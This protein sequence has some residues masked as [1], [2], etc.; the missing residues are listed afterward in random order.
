MPTL[1]QVSARR[2]L[3][4]IVLAAAAASAVAAPATA[5]QFDPRTD[6]AMRAGR[7]YLTPTVAVRE[8]GVD[9]NVFNDSEQKSDFTVTLAPDVTIWA[10]L[11]N[12]A[13]LR[14]SLGTDLVYYQT[15]AS[16]RSIDP[17]MQ[18]RAEVSLN[19][20][21]LFV[22]PSYLSTRQRLNYEVD[23]RA[24]R[25]ERT[26]E[27]GGQFRVSRTL[28][29]EVAGR[30]RRVRFD[31]DQVFRGT[32]LDDSL[33]RE[34][35][36]VSAALTYELT[37]LTAVVL[38][39][40][41]GADRFALSPSRDATSLRV[42]PGVEFKPHALVTGTAHVGVRRFTPANP[43]LDPFKGVV[44]AVALETTVGDSMR[45]S[46]VANRDVEYSYEA[47][48]QYF[49]IRGY[50]AT[51]T[52]QLVGRTDVSLGALRQAHSYR[53][54]HQ[55]G[56][57]RPEPRRIDHVRTVNASVGYRFVPASRVG[58]GFE[59]LSRGSNSASHGRAYHGTRLVTTASYGF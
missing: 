35:R 24:R 29:L 14:T 33:N 47:T 12:R 10:P 23:A 4:R 46:V 50:G 40:E 43:L 38:R 45:V 8:F 3:A 11:S 37:P 26:L 54:L 19:R 27:A 22:Q 49:V 31:G 58:V 25:R 53:G 1:P 21:T 2:T 17:E 52:R 41:T 5:Q 39:T 30:S 16:E 36:G 55:P 13:L 9:S 34:S 15:Y 44:A 59:Y 42:T 28:A 20:I 18:A 57:T 56:A 32:E 51:V 6:A 48:Q 7:L